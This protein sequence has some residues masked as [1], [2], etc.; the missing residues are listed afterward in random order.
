M[1]NQALVLGAS[2]GMGYSIVQELSGRGIKVV[3]FARNE[4]KLNQMFGE[5][6]SVSIHAGDVLRIEELE[7]AA[8][9][10][11]IIFH[12]IN[13]PYG[14][15]EKKLLKLTENVIT[16]AKVQSTKLAVVDN[17]YGYG[18]STGTAIDETAS[19]NPHTKKGKL[20]VQMGKLIK[21]SGT[22]Y[23]IA[24]FPDFYGPYAENGQINYTLRQVLSDKKAVF[25]GKQTIAREH[26]YTPD[27]A[28]ALVELALHENAYG[29]SWNIP[30]SDVITG[31]EVVKII[32]SNTGY[33]KKVSTVTKGMI[34]L[35]GLFNKQMRE[36]AEMQY[37]NEKPVVLNGRKYEATMG[38]VPRTSYRDGLK[39][40]IEVY[41]NA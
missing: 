9:G 8:K 26:I 3:A 39:E 24:H 15:W 32:R 29:Q 14:D 31:E 18:R 30:A 25:I 10:V 23:I 27:G 13:I 38:Q 19:K 40:T 16:V 41:R 35:L 20:R 22:L 11:D 4:R 28:R 33:N 37:L 2:G 34:Q 7:A 5:D 12:A 36:F 17:I 21:D 1:M 6:S